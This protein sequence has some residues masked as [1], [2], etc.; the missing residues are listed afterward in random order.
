MIRISHFTAKVAQQGFAKILEVLLLHHKNVFPLPYEMRGYWNQLNFLVLSPEIGGVYVSV[1]IWAHVQWRG[2]EGK[3]NVRELKR[4]VLISLSF[5][6]SVNHISLFCQLYFS[7]SKITFFNS[8]PV[9]LK[10]N[11][12]EMKMRVVRGI[13][14]SIPL[15]PIQARARAGSPRPK[16]APPPPSA[17]EVVSPSLSPKQHSSTHLLTWA[18]VDR[19]L[20]ALRPLAVGGSLMETLDTVYLQMAASVLVYICTTI[21]KEESLYT[22]PLR[23]IC[24]R[25]QLSLLW[26]IAQ[27][28]HPWIS[29]ELEIG[30]KLGTRFLSAPFSPLLP[31]ASQYTNTPNWVKMAKCWKVRVFCIG[32]GWT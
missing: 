23:Y 13:S 30:E 15:S 6:D 31:L 4:R 10:C 25:V 7:C 2:E 16:Q 3:C 24:A 8:C 21:T 22:L 29:C 19:G 26:S 28:L 20:L 32:Q 18:R 12:R 11:L 27:C 17:P 1:Q 9:Y 5:P 14:L